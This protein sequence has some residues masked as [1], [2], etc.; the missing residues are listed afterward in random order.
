MEGD[1]RIPDPVNPGEHRTGRPGRFIHELD[2]PV[3]PRER[4]CDP[5][6]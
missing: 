3:D 1:L 5:N 2:C 4:P 6:A